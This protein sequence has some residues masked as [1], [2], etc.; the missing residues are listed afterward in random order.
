M[1]EGFDQ[2]RA[3]IKMPASKILITNAE[4]KSNRDYCPV[5]IQ[6]LF[7]DGHVVLA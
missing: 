1:M 6:L 3:P 7:G 4:K 2:I 5:L